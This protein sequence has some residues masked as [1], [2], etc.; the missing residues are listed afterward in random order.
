MVDDHEHHLNTI[1][2]LF[3]VVLNLYLLVDDVVEMLSLIDYV[4]EVASSI[5]HVYLAHHHDVLE[6]N[7]SV[8]FSISFVFL[9]MRSLMKHRLL[10]FDYDS[11]NVETMAMD[12]LNRRKV[13]LSLCYNLK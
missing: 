9:R 10:H 3:H 6:S 11:M 1:E 4:L 8:K 13:D 12:L 5:H 2:I 7:L